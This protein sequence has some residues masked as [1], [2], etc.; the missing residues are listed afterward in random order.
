MNGNLFQILCPQIEL[1][2]AAS[3]YKKK[4]SQTDKLS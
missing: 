4:L 2:K 3:H 1:N